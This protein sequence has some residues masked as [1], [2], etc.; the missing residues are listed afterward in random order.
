MPGKV[1]TI[2]ARS[3][4][5]C[6]FRVSFQAGAGDSR[7]FSSQHKLDNIVRELHA[8][9]KKNLLK[10]AV[11]K[12]GA[13][14]VSSKWFVTGGKEQTRVSGPLS[15]PGHTEKCSPVVSSIAQRNAVSKREMRRASG[16]TLDS[17]FPVSV[18]NNE[19]SRFETEGVVVAVTSVEDGVLYRAKKKPVRKRAKEGLGLV[20]RWHGNNHVMDVLSSFFKF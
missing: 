15:E 4:N 9:E 3:E 7:P 8:R 6:R 20:C 13:F 18:G 11:V 17:P 5:S 2:V 14:D 19:P 10:R 16:R 12:C 1:N